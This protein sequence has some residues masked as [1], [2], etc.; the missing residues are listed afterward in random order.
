MGNDARR[1]AWVHRGPPAERLTVLALAEHIPDGKHTC[2]PSHETL[3]G[4]VGV[5]ERQIKRIL[6]TLEAGGAIVMK[7][8]QGRG[9]TTLYG[10]L[11]GLEPDQQHDVRRLVKGDISDTKDDTAM[12]PNTELKGDIQ[13]QKGDMKQDIAMSPF[14]Q[15]KVTS[16]VI[17]GDIAMSPR[18]ERETKEISNTHVADP[19][20]QPMFDA[21]ARACRIDLD[22]CTKAQRGQI[23]Q[24]TQA[25]RKA[26]KLPQEIP[27]I[28]VWWYEHDWRGKRGDAPRPAQLQEVWQQA[29]TQ[30]QS[31]GQ[32]QHSKPGRKQQYTPPTPEWAGWAPADLDKPL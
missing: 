13:G 2:W 19:D 3:A 27:K 20:F 17:K 12:S 8:G 5:S 18:T 30:E 10:L 4:L 28:E 1:R 7:I 22:L 11:I 6:Q 26:G 21:V 16:G 32:S 31:N 9:H 15:E 25:L 29:M 14:D 24:T 23:A